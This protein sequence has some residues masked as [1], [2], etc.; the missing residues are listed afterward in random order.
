MSDHQKIPVPIQ[1]LIIFVLVTICVYIA[2]NV[3]V[4]RAIISAFYVQN[5]YQKLIIEYIF[6]CLSGGFI[7]MLFVEKKISHILVRVLYT[8]TAVWTGIFVYLFFATLLFYISKRLF[9]DPRV[10]GVFFFFIA[11]GLGIYGVVHA[12]RIFI[13]KIQVALPNI[14]EIWKGRTAVWVSDVH[15]GS[16][17]QVNFAKKVTHIINSL[18]PDIIFIGGDLYD[19]TRASDL[20]KISEPLRGL[21]SKFGTLYITGNHEEFGNSGPFLDTVNKLGIKILQDELIEIDGLQ[22]IG[23]DYA[24]S[25]QKENFKSVLESLHINLNKPSVLLKHEPRD[26]DI[27]EGAGISLQISGHTHNG[28]QWPF[29]YLANYVYKGYAYGLNKHGTLNVLVSSGVGGWGP[30]VRVG[31]DSEIVHITFV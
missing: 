28:Q 14:P 26:L 19:G 21:T 13:K 27:A 31:T 25:A 1:K 16:I 6:V 22:I 5:A 29:N 8:M 17:Y 11:I 30:P 7:V 9:Y 4:F 24:N 18:S 20:Y 15:L 23:V 12:K 2:A 3:L 10:F